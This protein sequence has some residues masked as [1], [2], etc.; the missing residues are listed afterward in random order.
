MSVVEVVRLHFS[1]YAISPVYEYPLNGQW[2]MMD[3]DDG[4]ILWTG[5]WKGT[6]PLLLW[7]ILWMMALCLIALGNSKGLPSLNSS[8]QNVDS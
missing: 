1:N 8:S 3:V 6:L 7:T 4:Y 5:I 2:I